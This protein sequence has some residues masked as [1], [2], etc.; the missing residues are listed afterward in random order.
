[1]KFFSLNGILG[2]T[3]RAVSG[4][5]SVHDS[6]VTDPKKLAEILRGALLRI[7]ELEAAAAVQPVEFE[8]ELGSAGATVTISHNL[9]SAVRWWVTCW[10][11]LSAAGAYPST[12]ALIVQ[13][14]SSTADQLVL[15]S[16]TAGRAVIRV[17]P[18]SGSM[19][20]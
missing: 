8:I 15:R 20:A 17:E 1:M 9:H 5:A 14:A 12:G 4:A 7:S 18:N 2:R 19:E 16:Y 6:D 10:T 3:K 11:R 13:D